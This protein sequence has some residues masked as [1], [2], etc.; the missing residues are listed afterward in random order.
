MH[1]KLAQKNYCLY[2]VYISE[3]QFISQIAY[4]LWI[5]SQGT[6]HPRAHVPSADDC[7]A[8][9]TAENIKKKALLKEKQINVK[10]SH[11]KC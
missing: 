10:S 7:F 8:G 6:Y 9:Y 4:L 1:V 3:I 11:K 2:T 5:V